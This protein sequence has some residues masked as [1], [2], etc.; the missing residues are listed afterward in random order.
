MSGRRR[1][2][3]LLAAVAVLIMSA[4]LSR[5]G[6]AAQTAPLVLF[7]VDNDLG[8][9]SPVD[10]SQ[11]GLSKFADMFRGLG[12]RVEYA[13]LRRPVPA[14]TS[15]VVLA[16]PTKTITLIHA[17]RLWMYLQNGGNLLLTVDPENFYVGYANVIPQILRSGLVAL[18][19]TDYGILIR[20]GFVVEPAFTQATVVDLN[21]TYARSLA[22]V[23]SHPVI[24]PLRTYD[25]PVWVWG[26]RPLRVEPLGIDSTAIPLLYNSAGYVE[27][28]PDVFR[29]LRGTR[30]EA[31][32][33]PLEVNLG[34]DMVGWVNVAALAENTAAQSRIGVLGDSEMLMNG[35]GLN[36]QAAAPAYPGNDI[37]AE[38]IAAWLLEIEPDAWPPLPQGFTWIA[39]DGSDLDWPE[40][41]TALVDSPDAL[42]DPTHD[43]IGVR[44]MQDD[45]YLY[46]YIDTGA[47]PSSATRVDIKA[48]VPEN[49]EAEVVLSGYGDGRVVMRNGSAESPVPDG[50]VGIGNG[51]ELRIPRR[52]APS[53]ITD[54]CVYDPAIMDCVG[55]PVASIQQASRAPADLLLGNGLVVTVSSTVNVNLR[56]GPSTGTPVLTTIP[57]GT[58]FAAL[59]RNADASW[60]RV[61]NAAYSGWLHESLIVANGDTMQLPQIE[62]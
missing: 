10:T 7:V 23:V 22:D 12:A 16:R 47:P 45:R 36:G 33:A 50:A 18:L 40:D 49:G 13:D 58:A 59:G 48:E 15:V 53:A 14:D 35:Y 31:P 32:R 6:V 2:L 29:R 60:I 21:R 27:T 26:A 44:A 39:V 17:V 54:V 19:S 38:R 55:Q 30:F 1:S 37:F 61:E 51:I 9:A 46:L 42:V 3:R 52:L 62:A 11:T 20:D 8:S 34:V 28:N 43:I 56:E 57:D 4:V 41:V 24:A 25:L 5:D